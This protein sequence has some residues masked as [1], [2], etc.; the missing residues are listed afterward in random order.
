MAARAL[1]VDCIF[2]VC[3]CFSLVRFI[4]RMP[5]VRATSRV[6]C[7]YAHFFVD[8][9]LQR[10]VMFICHGDVKNFLSLEHLYAAG[11]VDTFPSM[12]PR[13]VVCVALATS[14]QPDKQIRSFLIGKANHKGRRNAS[15]QPSPSSPSILLSL[16][17]YHP[18]LNLASISP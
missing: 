1:V 7:Q 5:W 8:S 3:R 16:P 6:S 13:G 14:P 18:I 17:L 9:S 2:G 11:V 4:D 10:L 15:T 12:T